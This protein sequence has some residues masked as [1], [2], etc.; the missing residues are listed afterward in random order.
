MGFNTTVV[1]MNDA[2]HQIEEDKEFGRKLA[3]AALLTYNRGRQDVSAGNHVNAATVIESHH[4]D[5][6]HLIAVGG[7]YGQD[8]GYVG[9][10]RSTPE[11]MLRSLADQLGYRLVRK[12]KR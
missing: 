11:D 7:N 4:A 6:I 8:L 9:G 5:G 3:Q 12:A 1:V 2:L 10:Y